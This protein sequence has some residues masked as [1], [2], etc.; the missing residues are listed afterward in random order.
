MRTQEN[1]GDVTP[2]TDGL[3]YN[4]D[5]GNSG[6]AHSGG[7]MVAGQE[8]CKSQRNENLSSQ[9]ISAYNRKMS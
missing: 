8:K 9:E 1:G 3:L 5:L 2:D 6:G 7:V 4:S